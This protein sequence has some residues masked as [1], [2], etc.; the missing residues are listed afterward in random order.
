MGLF[1]L[2]QILTLLEQGGTL[3]KWVISGKPSV[4]INKN[5][6][7]IKELK[8]NNLGVNDLIES[9][10]TAG[11][12][13]LDE[14]SYA[15]YEANGSLSAFPDS[16]TEPSSSLPILIVAE[17]KINDKE[18]VLNY[19][20]LPTDIINKLKYMKLSQKSVWER[21][22]FLKDGVKIV[23]QNNLVGLGGDCWQ[24]K[25]FE[26]QPYLNFLLFLQL[27]CYFQIL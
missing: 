24:Y 7:D 4:V 15:I 26:V 19:R 3:I 20:F 13:S 2:H 22:A 8:K 12:F 11:Y 10:R 27:S 14:L 17:G 1:L 18:F 16:Q 25:Q 6:V 5:G 9:I 21:W 23:L